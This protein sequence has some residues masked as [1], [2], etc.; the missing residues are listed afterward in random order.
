VID[1]QCQRDKCPDRAKIV[2]CLGNISD[3]S[4]ADCLQELQRVELIKESDNGVYQLLKD[5]QQYSLQ[6]FIEA[7]YWKLPDQK[8]ILASDF[9]N[10]PL[11]EELLAILL[12]IKQHPTC[13]LKQLHR[14]E[15]P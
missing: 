4:L 6:Q 14:Q 1:R 3:I 10:Q 2:A 9:A 15:K 11:A 5:L 12:R 7:V 8:T 13:S